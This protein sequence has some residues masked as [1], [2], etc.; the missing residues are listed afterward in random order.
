MVWWSGAENALFQV[1]Q[2]ASSQ[3]AARQPGSSQAASQATR[4]PNW[5]WTAPNGVLKRSEPHPDLNCLYQGHPQ[6]R[7]Q[8]QQRVSRLGHPFLP[9][10]VAS[11]PAI[12]SVRVYC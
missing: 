10:P 12:A 3:A 1:A 11:M 5:T 9:T 8:H 4:S 6:R 7:G 2:Y